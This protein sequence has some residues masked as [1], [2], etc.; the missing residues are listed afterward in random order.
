MELKDLLIEVIGWISTL[1]FLISIILPNRIHLH[2]WGLFTSLT[3][4]IYAYA[5]NA[6]AIWVKWVIAFFFHLYMFAKL[7]KSKDKSTTSPG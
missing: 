5:H 7:L 4:G 2:S 1:A 3:T 6:T